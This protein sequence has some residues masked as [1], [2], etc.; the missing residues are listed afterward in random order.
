M[1][2]QNLSTL[3]RAIRL[4]AGLLMLWIGWTNEPAATEI[5]PVAL[6]ILA[7]LPLVTGL[8]GWCPIYAM[9]GLSTH[10]PK[11]PPQTPEAPA[12]QAGPEFSYN[13]P[14]MEPRGSELVLGTLTLRRLKGTAVL[15]ALVFILLLE[16]VRQSLQPFLQAWEGKLLLGGVLLTGALC[17]FAA[18]FQLI[19]RMQGRLDDLH[20]RLRDLAVCEERQRIDREMHDGMAQV[21]AYVNTKA[22]VVREHL[23]KERTDEA[24]RH[25]DQLAAAAREIYADARESILGLRSAAAPDNTTADSLREYAATWEAESGI[26]CRLRLEADL[27]LPALVELQV[28]RIVQEALAN[29]RKHSKARHAD[30]WVEQT[31]NRIRITVQD[32]GAGFIPAELGRAEYPRFG[33]SSMRE[34]AESVGGLFQLDSTPGEGTRVTLEVPAQLS[35]R[36]ISRGAVS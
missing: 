13:A 30:L 8:L 24:T 16:S 20:H 1:G 22:Q 35:H 31:G 29:V 27:R 33:L 6:R 9:L 7:W 18:A 3:D 36:E 23:K 10:K 17:F 21:L 5:W 19:E 4:L 25:L 34:R 14:R 15:A 2:F 32:D 11:P 26:R 12:L 28:L